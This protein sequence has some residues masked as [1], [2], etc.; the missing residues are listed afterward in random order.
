MLLIMRRGSVRYFDDLAPAV[1]ELN[2]AAIISEETP[3]EAEYELNL[4]LDKLVK[5]NRISSSLKKASFGDLAPDRW[6]CP[7][8]KSI[9]YQI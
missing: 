8:S 6:G 5:E 3:V 2:M 4:I 1:S 7:E 9:Q